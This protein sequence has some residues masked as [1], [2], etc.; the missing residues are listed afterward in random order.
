MWL[1]FVN[2][3]VFFQHCVAT[4]LLNLVMTSAQFMK[5]TNLQSYSMD[6]AKL[7]LSRQ[8]GLT[9]LMALNNES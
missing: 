3:G 1:V 7:C 6:L 4:R 5:Y 9:I 8:Y 2:Q